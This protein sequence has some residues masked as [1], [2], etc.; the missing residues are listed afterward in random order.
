MCSGGAT[1]GSSAQLSPP[2]VRAASRDSGD[3]QIWDRSSPGAQASGKLSEAWRSVLVV[4]QQYRPANVS[5]R[6]RM[7]LGKLPNRRGRPAV[8]AA[9]D[10][11]QVVWGAS[12][13]TNAPRAPGQP[14]A[15][16]RSTDHHL[17]K[18]SLPN[19]GRES[20]PD[21]VPFRHRVFVTCALG[22]DHRWDC[23]RKSTILNTPNPAI[24]WH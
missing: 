16:Q 18:G 21:F 7:W 24:S 1:W 10:P 14:G 17:I 4:A 15:S 9:W 5:S 13:G 23:R 11:G 22:I 6:N 3:W 8:V 20:N 12:L 2:T 19:N